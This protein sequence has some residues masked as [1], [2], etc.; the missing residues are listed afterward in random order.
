MESMYRLNKDELCHVA[1]QVGIRF[2]GSTRKRDMQTKLKDVLL[3][4][5]WSV[6]DSDGDNEGINVRGNVTEKEAN[7]FEDFESLEG[8]SNSDKLEVLKLKMQMQKEIELEKIKSDKE[9][10][11]E[12]D[13]TRKMY[14]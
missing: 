11:T 14:K 5:G 3:E 8:L 13:G 1:N 4:Q 12:R 6:G 7:I 2:D 9:M 10:Q